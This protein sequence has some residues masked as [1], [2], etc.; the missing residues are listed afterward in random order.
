MVFSV[1]HNWLGVVWRSWG[2]GIKRQELH[3]SCQQP[4]LC[5]QPTISSDFDEHKIPLVYAEIMR[6]S[7]DLTIILFFFCCYFFFGGAG[8]VILF[9]CFWPMDW[10]L[11]EPK[12]LP[13]MQARPLYTEPMK[14]GAAS[15]RSQ[16]D[17]IS[18]RNLCMSDCLI[19]CGW[20]FPF[21]NGQRSLFAPWNPRCP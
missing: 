2:I 21:G 5:Q 11:P 1:T 3:I 18:R 13:W 7:W 12:S 14:A 20:C 17:G 8:R 9:Y 15:D 6:R 19:V 4:Q 10:K 16:T